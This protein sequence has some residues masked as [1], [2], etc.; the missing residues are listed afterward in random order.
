MNAQRLGR[1]LLLAAL[2]G[3]AKGQVPP[4]VAEAPASFRAP[5]PQDFVFGPGD[6]LDIKVWRQ[7]DLDMQVTVAPDGSISLPLV[8]HLKVSGT[9]YPELVETLEDA[10][11]YYIVDPAVA[12]NIVE[13]SNQKVLI[14]GEVKNPAVLQVE[15]DLSILEALVRTGGIHPDASTDNV[16]L[17]RG[18]LEEPELYL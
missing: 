5:S 13:V 9:N 2:S 6:V 4:N 18:E 8:G 14:L 3:C 7:D 11:S 12:V 17:I 15:S 1:L 16:L 10:F